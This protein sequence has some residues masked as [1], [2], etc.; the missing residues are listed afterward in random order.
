MKAQKVAFLAL[1]LA[2]AFALNLVERSF[3]SF[4]WLNGGSIMLSIIPLLIVGIRYGFKTGVLI[5]AVYGMMTLFFGGFVVH[6]IQLFLDYI[7]SFAMLGLVGLI[8]HDWQDSRGI[9]LGTT[10]AC[11]GML[12]SFIVSGAIF[13]AEYAPV[14]QSAW[15]YSLIYNSTYMLPTLIIAIIVTPRLGKRLAKNLRQN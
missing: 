8:A 13:F 5:G 4:G 10:L 2:L 3:L 9:L 14:G 11:L 6:P 1:A 12:I 7:I 15:V